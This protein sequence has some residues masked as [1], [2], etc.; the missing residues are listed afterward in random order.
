[1]RSSLFGTLVFMALYIA[2]SWVI[3]GWNPATNWKLYVI[4]GLLYLAVSEAVR[5]F[6][7][8]Q[9]GDFAS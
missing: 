8:H 6:R 5:R 3:W 9:S 1:M 4:T 7:N 2:A